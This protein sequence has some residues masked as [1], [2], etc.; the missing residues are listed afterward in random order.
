MSS[1]R[2]KY[3]AASNNFVAVFRRLLLLQEEVLEI[4][5]S[6]RTTNTTTLI[7]S[8]MVKK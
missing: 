1:A 4:N 8:G 2:D 7:S 6:G 5:A 3:M